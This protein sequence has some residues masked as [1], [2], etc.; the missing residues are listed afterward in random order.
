MDSDISE[1]FTV[2]AENPDTGKRLSFGFSSSGDAQAKMAQLKQAR[3]RSVEV[4]VSKLP[5]VETSPE[6]SEPDL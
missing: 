1:A 4:I 3:F 5:K 6:L 2:W